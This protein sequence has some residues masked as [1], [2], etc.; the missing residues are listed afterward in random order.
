M[1]LEKYRTYTRNLHTNIF[2]QANLH[3]N[4]ILNYQFHIFRIGQIIEYVIQ[5][6]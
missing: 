5:N 4:F 6:I 2:V 1:E 3:A